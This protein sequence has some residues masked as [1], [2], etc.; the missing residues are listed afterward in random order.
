[1][2]GL[3]SPDVPAYVSY[4]IVLIFGVIVAWTTVNKR[5][6]GYPDHWAF[7]GTWALFF[8]HAV[9]P[10]VLF[11]FLDYTSA[12]H[13]TS[14][15]AALIVS[16]GYRQIFAGGVQGITMPGQSSSLWKPFEA[17]VGTVADRIGTKQKLYLD[18]FDDKVRSLIVSNPQKMLDLETLVLSNSRDVTALKTALTGL[19]ITGNADADLRLKLNTLWR[20]LRTSQ[21]QEYGWLLHK[22][23]IVRL[24]SYWMWLSN[25]R[26]KIISRSSILLGVLFV[27]GLYM[28]SSGLGEGPTRTQT[29]LVRFHQWRFLKPNG[30]ERDQWRS[31]EFL[32]DQLR[33][34][35]GASST[36]SGEQ[37]SPRPK[38]AVGS[39]VQTLLD[40]LLKELRFPSIGDRQ[41]RAVLALVVNGH[42]PAVDS[43]VVPELIE[44]LRT[45]SETVRLQIR[46]ALSAIQKADYPGAKLPD[47]LAKWEARKD[48]SPGDIDERVR[49]WQAWW[50]TAERKQPPR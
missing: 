36:K 1:V 17:W 2:A 42:S 37:T 50:Q 31:M 34:S 41:G 22:R 35:S 21:P 29:G 20:D 23:G 6:D 14:I 3:T 33:H 25:G 4:A 19:P 49:A 16:V 24:W 12:L 10:V 18:R 27:V 46:N 9:L 43:Y 30:T 39:S 48:E 44:S 28:W 40:P 47:T 11:W 13:D 5:L 26:S 38:V 8:A 45:A 15:F 32:S 7:L